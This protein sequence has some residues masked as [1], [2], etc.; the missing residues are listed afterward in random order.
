M[1]GDDARRI[2]LCDMFCHPVEQL[3]VLQSQPDAL[4]PAAWRCSDP[5]Q[6]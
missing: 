2:Q 5:V 3:R 4:K 1:R 6:L